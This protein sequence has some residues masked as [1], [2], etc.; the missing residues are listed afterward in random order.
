MTSTQRS[1]A[2]QVATALCLVAAAVC[3]VL[4]WTRPAFSVTRLWVFTD[5]VSIAGGVRQLW[6]DGDIALALLI[7]AFSLVVPTLKLVVLT[8]AFARAP[9]SDL[10]VLWTG[11]L[12]RW[13]MLDV[14]VVAVLVV[15]AHTTVLVDVVVHEGIYW[16]AASVLLTGVAAQGAV[17]SGQHCKEGGY[18]QRGEASRPDPDIKD[19]GTV[20][21]ASAPGSPERAER[22]VEPM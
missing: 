17:Q 20:F 9:R 13:S 2:G 5:T 6:Q 1:S 14:L 12:S 7:G 19:V 15:A 11:R 16:F 8:L 4:G 18:L 3:L 22:T 21:R 10:W